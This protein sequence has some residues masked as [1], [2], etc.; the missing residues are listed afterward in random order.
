MMSTT[1]FNHPRV[2]NWAVKFSR[3]LGGSVQNASN[4]RLDWVNNVC[5][6]W[7]GEGVEILTGIN[8]YKPEFGEIRSSLKAAALIK[9]AGY[10][11]LEELVR[12]RFYEVPITL[13]QRGDLCIVDAVPMV[14]YDL[15]TMPVA[16]GLV[17]PPFYYC[18]GPIGLCRGDLLDVKACFLVG[19]ITRLPTP[20]TEE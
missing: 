10:N 19:P 4:L 14:D 15:Q 17:D 1:K 13:A 7:A 8:P 18:V 2:K 3:F 11:T 16:I 6:S 20:V 5:G 9:R 12:D